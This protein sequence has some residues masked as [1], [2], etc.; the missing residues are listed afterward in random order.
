[1]ARITAKQ[2]QK[3]PSSQFALPGKGTGKS[4]KGPGSYPIDTKARA[5]NALARGAQHASSSQLAQIKRKVHRKFPDIGKKQVGAVVPRATVRMPRTM[6][7]PIPRPPRMAAAG[8]RIAAPS[9][10]G[11]A[12]GMRKGGVMPVIGSPKDHSTFK[13]MGIG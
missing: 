1:M 7:V 11:S 10:Y 13:Q 6:A 12:M 5:R 4:G 8:P 2:R 3:L 9:R